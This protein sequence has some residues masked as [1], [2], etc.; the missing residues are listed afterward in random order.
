M[1]G[2]YSFSIVKTSTLLPEQELISRIIQFACCHNSNY[3]I[4]EADFGNLLTKFYTSTVH[5]TV[6]RQ[7]FI[8][9]YCTVICYSNMFRLTHI[10]II[11][12]YLQC[13]R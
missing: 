7:A 4:S 1:H 9:V 5:M 8:S 3:N 6:N 2:L 13:S 10:A 11:R 12:K